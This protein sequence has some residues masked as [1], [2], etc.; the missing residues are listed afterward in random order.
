MAV[1]LG[2]NI[3]H[4][5]TIRQARAGRE[6]EPVA[7]AL[8]AQSAG[9]HGITVHLRADRRHIQERDV[10]ILR[11]VLAVPLNVEC[12]ATAEAMEAVI[13]IKPAWVTLVPETRE[14][15][16]TQGGLD[17]LFLHAHLRSI[18]RELHASEIRVSLFID[19]VQEQVK[20]AA[21]LEAEAVEF[22]TGIYAD[23]T[24]GADPAP[25]LARLREASRLAAKLGLKV[26]AGHGLSLQ[27]VGPVAAIP[28]VEELNIGHAIIGRAILVGLDRAV[29][30]MVEAVNE[31]GL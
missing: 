18:I 16:T 15:L 17:A 29:R 23:I 31:G 6:P 9:A 10:R 1:R 4:V 8:L 28:E 7:A 14:E 21:K 2:V 19:P 24:P 27:N 22:N 3:D 5:A 12:A 25:E 20:M 26:L 30:E 11:E 13:P